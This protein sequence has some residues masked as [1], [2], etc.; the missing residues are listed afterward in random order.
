MIKNLLNSFRTNNNIIILKIESNLTYVDLNSNHVEE[1]SRTDNYLV[2]FCTL[3]FL[4]QHRD[5]ISI[6]Q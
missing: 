5:Q 2:R 1:F 4:I 3:G 6:I